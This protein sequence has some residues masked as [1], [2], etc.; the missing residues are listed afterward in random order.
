MP[1]APGTTSVSLPG[2][3]KAR[4]PGPSMRGAS[5]SLTDQSWG[6]ML[7]MVATLTHILPSLL[8]HRQQRPLTG[9][10]K[11]KEEAERASR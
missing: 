11:Y 7:P 9:V 2:L 1:Q 5:G 6:K 3:A 8:K 4:P 10:E